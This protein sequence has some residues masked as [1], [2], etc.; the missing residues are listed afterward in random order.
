MKEIPDRLTCEKSFCFKRKAKDSKHCDNHIT[1]DDVIYRLKKQLKETEKLI[2]DLAFAAE[3]NHM[4][5]LGKL[6]IKELK[7][8]MEKYK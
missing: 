3:Q 1:K 8:I 2:T 4:E 5:N 7:K 6:F